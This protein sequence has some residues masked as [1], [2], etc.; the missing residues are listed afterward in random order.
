MTIL[1]SSYFSVH[2][3]TPLLES[4]IVPSQT[5]ANKS[6]SYSLCLNMST[7]FPVSNTVKKQLFR[8]QSRKLAYFLPFFYKHLDFRNL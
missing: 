3:P 8:T 6:Y 4:S 1:A 2:C 5:D 7:I